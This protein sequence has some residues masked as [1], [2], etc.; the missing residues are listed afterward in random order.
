MIGGNFDGRCLRT[1]GQC[2]FACLDSRLTQIEWT[3][4]MHALGHW[5]G[6]IGYATAPWV[7]HY[8]APLIADWLENRQ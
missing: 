1:A 6:H 7:R 5:G 8:L 3:P 2:G 4:S